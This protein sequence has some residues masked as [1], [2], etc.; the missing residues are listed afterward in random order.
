MTHQK[1]S[2]IRGYWKIIEEKDCDNDK[3]DSSEN[4]N[5]VLREVKEV[6]WIAEK[7]VSLTE[8]MTHENTPFTE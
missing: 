7:I 1:A 3:Q 4:L 5:L 8:V 2:D 6:R